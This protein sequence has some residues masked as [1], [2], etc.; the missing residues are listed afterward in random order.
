MNKHLT[1]KIK[2]EKQYIFVNNNVNLL[3]E[4][5]INLK[6]EKNTVQLNQI[7]KNSNDLMKEQELN[8]EA[9]MENILNL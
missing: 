6:R 4:I 2:L 9:V 1:N 5:Q 8:N 3:Q 7:L